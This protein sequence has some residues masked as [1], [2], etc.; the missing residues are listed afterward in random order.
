MLAR[1]LPELE[2]RAL[3]LPGH[4]APPVDDWSPAAIAASLVAALPAAP[5]VLVGHSW[6][7][8]LAAHLAARAPARVSALVLLEGGWFDRADLPARRPPRDRHHAAALAALFATP[9]SRAW[10]ALAAARVPTL[11]VA[12]TADTSEARRA[13]LARFAAAVP[14]A[15][16][17]DLPTVGHDL[18]RD[19]PD[20]VAGAIAGWLRQR[21]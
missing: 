17:L 14:H 20:E 9:S 8:A 18:L 4:E 1:A 6:G 21:A 12:A 15:D 16:L 19:A 5:S 3:P 13:L 2:V 10:P 11:A 7:A